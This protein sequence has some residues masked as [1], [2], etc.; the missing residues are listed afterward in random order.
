MEEIEYKGRKYKC[1]EV[2]IDGVYHFYAES[3]LNDDIVAN[4]EEG[5]NLDLQIIFYPSS[6][7]LKEMSGYV[8]RNDI[9]GLKKYMTNN[10]IYFNKK[11]D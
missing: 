1:L 11:E 9:E 10:S 5:C 4:N 6:D 3:D 8:S 2:T 7:E